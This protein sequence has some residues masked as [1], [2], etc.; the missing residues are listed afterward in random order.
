MASV[1][2]L[3]MELGF[4]DLEDNIAKLHQ[5]SDLRLDGE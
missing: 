3:G 4:V 5:V 1:V 2:F